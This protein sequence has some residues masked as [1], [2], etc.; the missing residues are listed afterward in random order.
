M[1]APRHASGNRQIGIHPALLIATFLDPRT[2]SLVSVPDVPSRVAIKSRVNELMELSEAEHR[3]KSAPPAADAVMEEELIEDDDEEEDDDLFTNMEAD[4]AAA[5]AEL[6]QAGGDGWDVAS[7][8]A[9]ELKR[10]MATK[11]LRFRFKLGADWVYEDPLL[12]WKKNE[13]LFPI[14][15]RLARFYLALPATS[16]PSERILSSFASNICTL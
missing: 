12:W 15:G 10:Y 13:S 7:A 11:S 5:D 9:D 14:L 1:E 4:V 8:C 2:K 16:A 3:N 6:E